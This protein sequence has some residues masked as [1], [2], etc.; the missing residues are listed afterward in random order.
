MRSA[1]RMRFSRPSGP[2]S[3][4]RELAGAPITLPMKLAK[5]A[6]KSA[7]KSLHAP[8]PPNIAETIRQVSRDM[9]ASFEG[10]TINMDMIPPEFMDALRRVDKKTLAESEESKTPKDG[11]CGI[12][13]TDPCVGHEF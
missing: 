4:I 13:E 1:M 8:L 9:D 3:S 6:E 2:V 11:K 10:R 7:G 12:C 5:S